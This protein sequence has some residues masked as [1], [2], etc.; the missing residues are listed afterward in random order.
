[1]TDDVYV[2]RQYENWPN[3]T[4]L[5]MLPDSAKRVLDVGCGTGA[6]LIEMKAGGR[7]VCG[8]TLSESEA[9]VVCGLGIECTVA[10]CSVPLP[11]APGA[12]DAII[13][14]HVL[15]HIA[16]PET[17]V[18]N[19]LPLL[20][21]GGALYAAVPNVMFFRTRF[22]L[23][24]GNFP[25]VDVGVFDETHLRWFTWDTPSDLARRAGCEISGQDGDAWFRNI[26]WLPKF[27]GEIAVK[28]RP[29]LFSQQIRFVLKASRRLTE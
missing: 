7:S 21:P 4:L 23:M 16:W 6:N 3:R 27:V 9:S 24:L 19:L 14:S 22:Q 25:R 5:R 12:F 28:V 1:M 29:N 15:E 20:A 8:V 10:D 17:A 18:K 11:F 26:P 2:R 13:A